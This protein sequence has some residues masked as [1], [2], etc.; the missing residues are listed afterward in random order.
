LLALKRKAK[1]M[2]VKALTN[3]LVRDEGMR[4]KPY[5]CTAG[6]LTIGV[7]RNIE[8]VG[9]TEDEARYLLEN[10]IRRVEGELDQAF[11]WWRQLSDRRQRALANMAFNLGAQ[12]LR[13]FAKMIKALAGAQY[14]E[15]ARQALDSKWSRQVGARAERIAAMIRE[16]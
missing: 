12:R 7:G 16:G 13:G 3:E 14:E 11:P 5:L 1:A 10:D 9:I 15:A 6:K 2:D 8:D 4:T